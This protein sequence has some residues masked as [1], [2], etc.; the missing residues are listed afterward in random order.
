MTIRIAIVEDDARIAELHRRYVERLENFD[1]VGIAHTLDEA[2][3]LVELVEPDLILLDIYFPSG[4]GF[5]LLRQLRARNS[6]TDVILISAAKEIEALKEA[7]RGGVYDFIIKPLVFDRLQETLNRY[8][9]QVHRLRGLDSICQA[10][11]DSLLPKAG[12]PA[13]AATGNQTRLPK[14]IDRLTLDKVRDL[15]TDAGLIITAEEAGRQIGASRTTARRYLEYLVTEGELI[16]DVLY[17]NVGR[18]ERQY[19]RY[20]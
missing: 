17:G 7:L 1:V 19:R 14:G 8:E 4:T 16:A 15:F 5:E 9:Q 10:D 13:G 2:R 12:A 6:S 11:V 3:D 18:P 20:A